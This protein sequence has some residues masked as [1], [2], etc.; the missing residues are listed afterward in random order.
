MI[1]IVSNRQDH[2]ADFLI[3]ELLR[4]RAPFVRLNTEDFAEQI[5]FRWSI[6]CPGVD[7]IEF[8][9]GRTV[10]LEDIRAIWYRRP[11]AAR[12][13][14]SDARARQF[15]STENQAALDGMLASLTNCNWVS[16]PHNIRRA[17]LKLLQLRV[18]EQLGF[19]L[20][21]TIVSNSAKDA[22]E[23][24]RSTPGRIIYKPLRAARLIGENHVEFIYT[25]VLS[26]EDTHAIDT[27]SGCPVLLQAY[28]DKSVELRIT[29]IGT[30]VFAIE[31]HSQQTV[32]GRDDWRRVAA[33]ELIHVEHK[34]PVH[35]R[36]LCIDLVSNLGLRF[37]AIDMVLTPSGDYVF[38]EINPNGQWAWLQQLM[39]SVPLRET[40]ADLLMSNSMG[41]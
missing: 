13:S 20:C 21:P 23:F 29:V 22:Q 12:L 11:V 26:V 24:L 14:D 18:A 27:I 7:R 16:H 15:S 34:L 19:A 5:L 41:M 10:P 33:S 9:S 25:N 35:V 37:G 31:L 32:A 36:T 4:R 17:E 28:A 6:G 30:E 1:V 40:L 38:L 8:S 39:P 3:V 2:T